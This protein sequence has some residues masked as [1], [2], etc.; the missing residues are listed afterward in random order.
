M[1]FDHDSGLNKDDASLDAEIWALIEEIGAQ[2]EYNGNQDSAE[3]RHDNHVSP[4]LPS[5]TAESV[6]MTIENIDA[7]IPATCSDCRRHH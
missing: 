2:S 7:L 4:T 1:F 5:D 3:A 6:I